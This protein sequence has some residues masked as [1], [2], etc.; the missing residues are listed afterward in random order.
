M[1]EGERDGK[2]LF[3]TAVVSVAVWLLLSDG[4]NGKYGPVTSFYYTMHVVDAKLD[5]SIGNEKPFCKEASGRVGKAK[6]AH[7]GS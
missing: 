3:I 6:C 5:F 1:H 7:G 4:Y 2:I